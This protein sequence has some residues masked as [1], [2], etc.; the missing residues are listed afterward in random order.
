NG[1]PSSH[2]IG[3]GEAYV[4]ADGEYVQGTWER[5][6]M[7]DWF[8]LTDADGNVIDVPPGKIWVSLVPSGSGLTVTE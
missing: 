8:T 6:E 7:T 2:T 1:L 5:E 4:F 3:S